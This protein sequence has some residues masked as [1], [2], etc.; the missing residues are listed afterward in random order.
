[1]NLE[2][3]KLYALSMLGT[4]YTYGTHASGGDDPIHGFDCSGFGSEIARAAGL[5]PWNY[6]SNAQGLYDRLSKGALMGAR[7]GAFSFY[8]RSLKEISHVG[9]CL[10]SQT[11][12][13][14]GGGD[15]STITEEVAAQKNAFVRMRPILYRKDFLCTVF[16]GYPGAD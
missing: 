2:L 4:R 11:M 10:D 5:V 12:I 3:L 1:M 14:A 16:P 6:R 13:E 9:F 15:S 8:G 7:L